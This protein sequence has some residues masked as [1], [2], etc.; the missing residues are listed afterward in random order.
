MNLE[1]KRDRRRYRDAVWDLLAP[2]FRE[3]EEYACA[4]RERELVPA[5]TFNITPLPGPFL[6]TYDSV[7]AHAARCGIATSMIEPPLRS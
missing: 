3:P 4:L 5:L 7:L 6:P 2:L 1:N